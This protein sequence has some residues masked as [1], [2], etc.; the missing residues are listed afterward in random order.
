MT[1]NKI[2]ELAE[3][4]EAEV[5]R[6]AARLG[7]SPYRLTNVDLDEA[8]SEETLAFDAT[9]TLNGK[10]IGVVRNDGRGGCNDYYPQGIGDGLAKE[11]VRLGGGADT[12]EPHD[13]FVGVL[14]MQEEE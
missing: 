3:R 1:D 9:V 11:W 10:P 14:L 12:I 4:Y 5:Q 6:V 7:E 2:A 13:A 8:R